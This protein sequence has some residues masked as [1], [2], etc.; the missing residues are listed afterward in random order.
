MCDTLKKSITDKNALLLHYPLV[1]RIY[2]NLC[3][4][5][6]LYPLCHAS[7]FLFQDFYHHY[8]FW[9]KHCISLWDYL[10]RKSLMF[11]I[12]VQFI[13]R[14]KQLEDCFGNVYTVSRMSSNGFCGYYAL[15]QCITGTTSSYV[16]IIHDCLQIFDNVPELFRLRTTYGG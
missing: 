2:A 14:N 5:D 12:C 8:F 15:A 3:V 1:T 13:G 7:L 10:P 4:C 9:P 16:S 6:I 11:S